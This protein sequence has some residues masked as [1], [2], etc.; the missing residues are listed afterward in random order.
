MQKFDALLMASGGLDSTV[1]AYWLKK[2]GKSVLPLFIDYGQHF[3]EEEFNTLQKVIPEEFKKDIRVVRVG[4]I[5]IN[6]NSRMI[7]EPDL[8][9]EEVEADDLYLPYRNL[10]FL[11]IAS[12]LAQTEGIAEV[13]SAFINS[14]HAK[15]IDCS[16]SFFDQL[17]TLLEGYGSVKVCMPFRDYSKL[18]VA[19]LGLELKVPIAIT[20]SCQAS[21][22]FHCGVC[23]NCVDR[24]NALNNL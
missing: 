14:N 19:Q 1:M 5:Y 20:Y 11:S 13:Y 12:S 4:D 22:K 8:W 2:Q 18:E 15:E 24:I 10:L 3:K 17:G 7:N 16:K 21:S 23:P 9:N 6:S